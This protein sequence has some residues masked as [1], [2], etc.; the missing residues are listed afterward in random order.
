MDSAL[1][2]ISRRFKRSVARHGVTGTARL[3]IVHLSLPLR[4]R[5]TALA[6]RR[7]D[8]RYGIDTGGFIRHTDLG[9]RGD[10]LHYQ[11]T[12]PKVFRAI[13]QALPA[14]PGR[15]TFVDVGCGKGRTL[16]LAEEL[17]FRRV[18]GV[19]ISH[20]LVQ[21]ARANLRARGSEAYVQ[22]VDAL[23]V[24]FPDEDLL[25]YLYNP[26]GEQTLRGVLHR[27]RR[28]LAATPRFALVA[29][30]MPAHRHLFDEP[31]FT[32]IQATE[33]WLLMRATA[34]VVGS[35]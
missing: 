10:G 6:D 23:H 22:H 27:L 31:E 30:L 14:S 34:S 2:A 26:F 15:L 28:S 4:R 16:I 18:I 7:F 29:Y 17:G 33:D 8:G 3:A 13:V 21:T 9:D 1:Q 35:E 11:A 12:A 19:E 5:W 32:I 25:I 24:D 20:E